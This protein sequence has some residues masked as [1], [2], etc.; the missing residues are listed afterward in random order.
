VNTIFEKKLF[1]LKMSSGKWK[2]KSSREIRSGEQK[3]FK[4]DVFPLLSLP[5]ELIL[6]ILKFLTM[7]DVVSVATF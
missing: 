1:V 3:K 5:N 4:L 2:R 6:H 7:R